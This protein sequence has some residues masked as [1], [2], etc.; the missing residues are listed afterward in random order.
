[1]LTTYIIGIIMN[2]GGCCKALGTDQG[3]VTMESIPVI[4]GRLS[5]PAGKTGNDAQNLIVVERF[6]DEGVDQTLPENPFE[7]LS[8]F[9]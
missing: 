6:A 7:G 8:V 2:E 5:L 4:A 9:F 3:I 1:M